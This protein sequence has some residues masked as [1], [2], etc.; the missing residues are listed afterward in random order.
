MT[1]LT[2]LGIAIGSIV[3]LL[4]TTVGPASAAAAGASVHAAGNVVFVLND[5]P[6]GNQVVAYD[7]QTDG[8]LTLAGTYSTGGNGGVLAGS[9]VDHTASQGALAY[10]A[11]RGLLF[12]VNPGARTI[13]VFRVAGDHSRGRRSSRPAAP[14]RSASPRRAHSSTCSTR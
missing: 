10:D 8:Q 3:A 5:N 13:A 4:M 12:A 6:A 9:V 11:S 14:S 7:R 2:R 1:L